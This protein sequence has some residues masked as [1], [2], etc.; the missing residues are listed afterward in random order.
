MSGDSVGT[1]WSCGAELEQE[2]FAHRES[3]PQCSMDIW[4][5]LNCRF[6]DPSAYNECREY[7]AERVVNKET[8]NF[9]DYFKPKVIS[10]AGKRAGSAEDSLRAAAEALFK[11]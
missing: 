5:C 4:V 8:A 3:C 10:G 11:K 9:C 6:H 2:E 7:Q 1:C